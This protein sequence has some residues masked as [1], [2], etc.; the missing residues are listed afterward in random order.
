MSRTAD[1]ARAYFDAWNRRDAAGI[2]AA[3]VEGGTYEDP[4][5]GGPLSGPALAAYAEGLF[6]AFPDLHFETGPLAPAGENQVLAEWRMSGTHQG[7]LQGLPPTGRP[8]EL[9]GAD[10]LAARDGRLRSVRGYFD[11]KSFMEQLG[12][13]MEAMPPP[14]GPVQFGTAVYFQAGN[15]AAPGVL[16]L[17]ALEVRSD[18]EAERT[19]Q[20]SRQILRET[21]ALPGFISALLVGV[22]RRMFTLTAWSDAEAS[23]RIREAPAHRE[24]MR[25]FFGPE[26][27]AGGQTSVWAAERRNAMWVR[28]LACERMVD[29][30]RHEG[31]CPCGARLPDHPPYL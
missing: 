31:A 4:A 29:A 20:L 8:I 21:A 12:V 11:Q 7:P 16:S 26:L 30:H 2:V 1:A 25:A 6:R 10:V 28:C 27:G 24:A 14:M 17:T 13:R 22:G 3:F 19:A 5:T 23:E 15:T 9:R 18:E